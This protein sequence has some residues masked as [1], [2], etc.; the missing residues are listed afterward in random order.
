MWQEF[1]EVLKEL[2]PKV[3]AKLCEY[4]PDPDSTWVPEHWYA[5]RDYPD[6][7]GKYGRPALVLITC[8]MLG[9]NVDEALLTAA[10]MQTSE[11]WILGHDDIEDK[12]N[13]RRHLPTLHRSFGLNVA[14][15]AGDT[16]HMVMWKMLRD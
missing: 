15:N 12:S 16:L 1:P 9:G 10:A 2:K 13:W 11:N 3:H 7:Q 8:E 4:L 6:R 14:L 5:V